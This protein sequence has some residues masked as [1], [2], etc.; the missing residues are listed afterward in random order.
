MI[1]GL[2]IGWLINKFSEKNFFHNHVKIIYWEG[3]AWG[4]S[5]GSVGGGGGLSVKKKRQI[6]TSPR[7]SSIP[8]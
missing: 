8:K 4:N 1:G 3:I 7:V 5:L 6:K 2:K